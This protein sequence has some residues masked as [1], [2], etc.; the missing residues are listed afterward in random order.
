MSDVD[1]NL[2]GPPWEEDLPERDDNTDDM[3]GAPAPATPA[4][5]AE[6]AAPTPE[7]RAPVAVTDVEQTYTVSPKGR[8]A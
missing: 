8:P 6:L 5:E 3:F 7:P 4:P 1:P 2:D